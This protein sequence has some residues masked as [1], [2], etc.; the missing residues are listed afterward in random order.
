MLQNAIAGGVAKRVPLAEVLALLCSPRAF[1]WALGHGASPIARIALSATLS[2]CFALGA[3][4]CFKRRFP[5]GMVRTDLKG[6]TSAVVPFYASR[7]KYV[8]T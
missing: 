8:L 4:L 2:F 6:F 7:H 3:T 5:A 1:W